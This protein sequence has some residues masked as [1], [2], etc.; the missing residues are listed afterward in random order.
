M[1]QFVGAALLFVWGWRIGGEAEILTAA[2]VTLSL[3]ATLVGL[4]VASDRDGMA[5]LHWL[6]GGRYSLLK[7][8]GLRGYVMVVVLLLLM[9]VAFV[10]L[11]L[12]DGK[13]PMGA[14][15]VLIAAPGFA[16]LML[17]LPVVVARWIPHPPWQTPAMIRLVFLGLVVLMTGVPPLIGEIVS[18]ADDLFLNALNPVVGL[19]NIEK[20]GQAGLPLVL[21]VWG[22]GLGLAAS[23]FFS[24]RSRDTEWLA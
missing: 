6:T 23:A 18:D 15:L 14:M 24:L 16:L 22:I 2:S 11:A 21:L 19:I 1:V 5:K 7:P 9:T 13:L 12:S 17:S 4:F 3:Y 8:G 10:S 20:Q